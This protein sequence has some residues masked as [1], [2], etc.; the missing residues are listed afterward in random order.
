MSHDL[1]PVHSPLLQQSWFLALPPLSD[2]LKFGGSF[3]AHQ[4]TSLEMSSD[5]LPFTIRDWVSSGPCP[6]C[7][8]LARSHALF[9]R[10][11]LAGIWLGR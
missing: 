2:M 6:A 11:C 10:I 4:V 1:L 9:P 7:P 8:V 5:S 3:H